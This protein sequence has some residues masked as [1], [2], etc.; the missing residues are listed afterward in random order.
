MSFFTLVNRTSKVL[1]GVWDGRH[2]DIPLG[3]S[4][5]P[6]I[7]AEKFR[8]QNPVMG[9]ED[10]RTLE[11]QYLIGIEEHN[12][13][14]SPIEQTTSMTL[15][16]LSDKIK[17]GELRIVKGNGLYNPYTDKA[18]PLPFDANFVKP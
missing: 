17:S 7:Q 3:K 18:T 8:E 5:F 12:D 9:S 16:D 11:K 14:C 10:P 4:Q 13:D 1:H 6:Q 15:Q 2:Y